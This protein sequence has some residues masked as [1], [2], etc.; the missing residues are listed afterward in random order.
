MIHVYSRMTFIELSVLKKNDVKKW[1]Y[2][3]WTKC[4]ACQTIYAIL[5]VHAVQLAHLQ[6]VC[7]CHGNHMIQYTAAVCC[8]L[9]IGII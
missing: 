5:S 3:N 7:V 1:C 6:V 4:A 8:H 2:F 9:L